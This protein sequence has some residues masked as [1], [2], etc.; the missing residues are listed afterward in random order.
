VETKFELIKTLLQL[1]F[2]FAENLIQAAQSN[3]I[4]LG[5]MIR[6]LLDEVLKF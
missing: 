5:P 2:V 1:L 3:E 4:V 6:I